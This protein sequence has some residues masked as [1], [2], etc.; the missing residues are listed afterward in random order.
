[1]DRIP[2][3][4]KPQQTPGEILPP[5]PDS[6]VFE[7]LMSRP[8][9]GPGSGK[10]WKLIEVDPVQLYELA[11]L[12]CTQAECAQFFGIKQ[13]TFESK[14][15]KEEQLRFAWD[16]GTA[17]SKVGIRRLQILHAHTPGDPGVKMT[18]HMSKFQ[19][20]ERDEVI[21]KNV[22]LATAGPVRMTFQFDS[23][24]AQRSLTADMQD[25]DSEE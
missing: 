3:K 13:K 23:P 4:P 25:D 15:A 12:G 5:D 17:Q 24:A 10:G 19:L 14:L 6:Q 7:R 2:I 20:G 18:I 16:R 8:Q 21:Q 22:N 1:M 11:R 9:G